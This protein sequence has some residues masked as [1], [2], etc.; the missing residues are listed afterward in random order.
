M[1]FPFI[2]EFHTC[3][4]LACYFQ[5]FW[6]FSKNITEQI[7]YPI[8]CNEFLNWGFVLFWLVNETKNTIGK[9]WDS[10]LEVKLFTRIYKILN[11]GMNNKETNYV[12]M[13]TSDLETYHL[14]I[15]F[16]LSPFKRLDSLFSFCTTFIKNKA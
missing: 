2:P 8:Q 12:Y 11:N 7:L 5:Y 3:C 9:I 1:E 4:S 14:I 16:V 10:P 13:W 15:T 6:D